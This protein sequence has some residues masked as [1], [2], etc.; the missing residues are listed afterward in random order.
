MK[1]LGHAVVLGFGPQ[2]ISF[3]KNAAKLCGDNAVLDQDVARMAGATMAVGQPQ[4]LAE[5]R[6]RLEPAARAQQAAAPANAGLS[7]EAVSWL[8]AGE[9]GL[10]SDTLF[11]ATTGVDVLRRN[12]YNYPHDPADLRRCRLLLEQV[13]EVRAN[14]RKV[15]HVHPVWEALVAR[16]DELCTLMD[17]E[18][19]EWRS[20]RGGSAKQTYKLMKE[21]LTAAGGF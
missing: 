14:F 16:W 12:G 10:S 20:A 15:A 8:A 13:P 4:D 1:D 7:A 6:K 2:P 5:L 18:T 3:F 17:G 11:T 21:I 9:R 19:P